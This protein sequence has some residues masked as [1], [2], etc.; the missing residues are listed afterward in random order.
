MGHPRFLVSGKSTELGSWYPG[1]Q[2]RDPGY[3]RFEVSGELDVRVRAGPLVRFAHEWGTRFLDG[4]DRVH[5]TGRGPYPPERVG[6]W[7][8]SRDRGGVAIP[9]SRAARLSYG[10]RTPS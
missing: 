6:D 2:K 3:P 7:F 5:R 1:S 9:N 8:V 10:A 4:I